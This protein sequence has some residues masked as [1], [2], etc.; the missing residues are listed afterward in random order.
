MTIPATFT[1]IPS[2]PTTTAEPAVSAA[3]TV[4]ALRG[5]FARPRTSVP[6]YLDGGA[7]AEAAGLEQIL[8]RAREAD[9]M[10]NEDPTAPAIEQQL[11]DAHERAEASRVDFELQ[12]LT[13]RAWARM[14]AEHPPT[15]DQLADAPVSAKP[16]FNVDT[17]PGALV[18]AQLLRPDPGTEQEWSE[19]WDD[20][21][22][23]QMAQLWGNAY[24]LQTRD[25]GSL[26][27][28]EIV[29]EIL[30]SYAGS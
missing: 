4:A 1:G 24:A 30:R 13:H 12:A 11:L 20:L 27:K 5:K 22:D 16:D 10:S 26:G 25:D 19:F 21:S 15:P 2:A 9:E 8:T 3:T 7:V 17:L 14:V 28:S 6:L 18:R 29:S 23:G